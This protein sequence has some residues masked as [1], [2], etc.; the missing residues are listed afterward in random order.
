[1]TSCVTDISED[2]LSNMLNIYPNPVTNNMNIEFELEKASELSLAI[3]D[4]LGRNI[5]NITKGDFSAGIHTNSLNTINLSN[6]TYF[7]ELV[8][9][10]KIITKKFIVN[11]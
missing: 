4:V 8:S 1:M 6:G 9:E 2:E 10:D 5:L 11:K 7:I 3:K